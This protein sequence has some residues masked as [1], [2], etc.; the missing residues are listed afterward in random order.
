MAGHPAN[1]LNMSS[2]SSLDNVA[3]DTRVL[4]ASG[5][6]SGEKFTYYLQLYE[7]C[8]RVNTFRLEFEEVHH[9]A[10]VR[11]ASRSA[12]EVRLGLLARRPDDML[13]WGMRICADALSDPD[14]A[15]KLRTHLLRALSL[16]ACIANPRPFD[17]PLSE[18][19]SLRTKAIAY[20]LQAFVC[21]DHV[22]R[23]FTANASAALGFVTTTVVL[24]A[25]FVAERC[26][27]CGGP[28]L[29]KL[30]QFA[31][32]SDLCR[33]HVQR[34][35]AVYRMH[36]ARQHKVAKA[37]NAYQCAAEGCGIQGTRKA[38]LMRCSGKCEGL[39]KPHY[40]SK[41]CQRKDWQHHKSACKK[42]TPIVPRNYPLPPDPRKERMLTLP[43]PGR[44][45]RWLADMILRHGA[46]R[47]G[48]LPE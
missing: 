18:P 11:F 43:I 14:D 7:R 23:A 30:P 33:A 36:L 3:E 35:E 9:E 8:C 6:F 38:A 40:C 22:P 47:L 19:P 1:V 29:R 39:N 20:C 15:D 17:P 31:V 32:L 5:F 24:V 45:G 13:E 26:A 10:Y 16:W 12:E 41:E 46:A 2:R 4:P 25:E 27:P 48:R 34:E 42:G 37:P 28:P 21:Y 44:P